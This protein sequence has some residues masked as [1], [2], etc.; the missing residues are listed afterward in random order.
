MSSSTT[1]TRAKIIT[2]ILQYRYLLNS[3][4][5]IIVLFGLSLVLSADALSDYSQHGVTKVTDL[6]KDARL[7]REQG[8][9]IL[10]E[11]SSDYCEYCRLLEEEFL[12][13]MSIDQDYSKKIIIRSVPFDG[14]ESFTGFRGESITPEEFA[15]RYDIKVTPTMVFLD[16]DGNELSDK[17]IGIWSVDFFGGYIDER[18]DSAREKVF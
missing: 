13:P 16:A 18:I 1:Y 8:L 11:F 5:I 2:R 6:S 7:A 4:Y 14:Y 17:L 3:L 15:S 9:V 10:I 12:K